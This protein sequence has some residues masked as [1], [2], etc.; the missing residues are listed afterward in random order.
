MTTTQLRVLREI[1][2]LIGRWVL[3]R[4]GDYGRVK[5]I[6]YMEGRVDVFKARRKRVKSAVRKRFLAGRIRRWNRAIKWLKT[7][8]KKL[9]KKLV[10][11]MNEELQ[12]QGKKMVGEGERFA[13]RK[14]RKAKRK[15]RRAVR[16]K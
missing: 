7:E 11:R 8:G 6:H 2:T 14:V 16:R 9:T 15:A 3:V 12:A 13:R 10:N 5:L 1:A 4:F